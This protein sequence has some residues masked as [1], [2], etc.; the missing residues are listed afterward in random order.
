M[1]IVYA[2]EFVLLS[3]LVVGTTTQVIV[4]LWKGTPIFPMFRRQQTLE[5]ELSRARGESV[6]AELE[7]DTAQERRR[8][9]RIR[10]TTQN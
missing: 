9:E 5:R 2:V 4:P 6:E 3:I 7:R 8:T 1:I 10:R